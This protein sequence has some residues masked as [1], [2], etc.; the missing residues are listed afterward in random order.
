MGWVLK[1]REASSNCNYGT[2]L[3]R[4]LRDQFV[5]GVSNSETQMKLRQENETFD[6]CIKL[7]I[8]GE[9]A[10]KEASAFKAGVSVNYFS[11]SMQIKAKSYCSKTGHVAK[12]CF[13]R[14][15]DE[16]RENQKQPEKIRLKLK[17]DECLLAESSVKYLDH[18]IDAKGL[19]PLAS[20]VEAIQNVPA[21]T[22]VNK[23][24]SFIGLISYYGKFLSNMSTVMAPLY[25]LLRKDTD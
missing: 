4:A 20:K 3:E 7:A 18:I 6:E 17:K 23:L 19:H 9:T 8:A 21:P 22:N 16:R 25:E 12:K 5:S 2:F 14:K 24:Q 13:S 10:T 11:N 1:L 15:K